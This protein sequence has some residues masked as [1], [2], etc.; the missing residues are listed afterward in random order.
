MMVPNRSGDPDIEGIT[1]AWLVYLARRSGVEVPSSRILDAPNQENVMIIG[2]LI[3]FT[4]LT[5]AQVLLAQL[6]AD[7]LTVL[8]GKETRD[9][10]PR[11]VNAH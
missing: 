11:F 1:G 8:A 2:G 10:D 4:A 3:L 6:V 9:F 7:K 5:G